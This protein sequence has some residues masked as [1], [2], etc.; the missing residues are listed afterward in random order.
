MQKQKL[1]KNDLVIVCGS[2]FLVGEVELFNISSSPNS[3]QCIQKTGD[4]H[5][6]H[7]LI[8]P[9]HLFYFIN[10]KQFDLYFFI[11]IHDSCEA[12][13]FLLL[14]GTCASGYCW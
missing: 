7:Y 8:F 12:L 4:M 13:S 5:D 1:H 3:F 11:M 2:V 6:L 10:S 14:Q 9:D